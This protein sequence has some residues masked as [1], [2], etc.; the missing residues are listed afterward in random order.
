[1]HIHI[2]YLIQKDAFAELSDLHQSL[3]LDPDDQI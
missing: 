2:S 1:M 3:R